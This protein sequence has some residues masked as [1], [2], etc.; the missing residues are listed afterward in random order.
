MAFYLN[1]TMEEEIL[2]EDSEEF[3][4]DNIYLGQLY[5]YLFPSFWMVRDLLLPFIQLMII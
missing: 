5:N 1:Q 2:D 4:E 3:V